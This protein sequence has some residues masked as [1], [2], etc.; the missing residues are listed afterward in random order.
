MTMRS[1]IRCVVSANLIVLIGLGA[2]LYLFYE[3]MLAIAAGAR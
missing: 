1:F 3:A 2:A